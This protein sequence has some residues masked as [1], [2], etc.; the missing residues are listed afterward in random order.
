MRGF[1]VVEKLLSPTQVETGIYKGHFG[2]RRNSHVEVTVGPTRNI[3]A[4]NK[5]D[6][7]DV[8]KIYSL[9]SEASEVVDALEKVLGGSNDTRNFCL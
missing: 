2:I 3:I 6:S 5:R 8:G 9:T 4:P 1:T 7:I